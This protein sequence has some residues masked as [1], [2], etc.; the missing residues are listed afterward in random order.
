MPSLRASHRRSFSFALLSAA[1]VF[2]VIVSL[3]L[4]ATAQAAGAF[5]SKG[6]PGYDKAIF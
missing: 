4:D 6:L 1:L 5:E 3:P 2:L